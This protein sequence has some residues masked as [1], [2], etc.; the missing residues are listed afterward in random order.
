MDRGYSWDLPHPLCVTKA[1]LL[2][3]FSV[4]K[5]PKS[6]TN[7]E[8]PVW[9]FPGRSVAVWTTEPLPS[10]RGQRAVLTGI[11]TYSGSGFVILACNTSASTTIRVLLKCLIHH[12]GIPH[13][14]ASNQGIHFSAK[15]V[16]QWTQAHGIHSYYIAHQ[17]ET[18]D[19]KESWNELLE[20]QLWFQLGD[21]PLKKIGS[22]LQ[23]TICTLTQWPI[24]GAM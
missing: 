24:Y 19:P 7:T 14:I 22:V 17:P 5:L 16:W 2:V 23:N 18:T 21:D 15:E 20:P 10:W 8:P 9:R 3:T 13:N 4:S 1:D 12:H 11:D 6:K